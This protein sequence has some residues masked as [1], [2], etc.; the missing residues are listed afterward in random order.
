[1]KGKGKSV[2]YVRIF[3]DFIPMKFEDSLLKSSVKWR[4]EIF[5]RFKEL[6]SFGSGG[7]NCIEI[8]HTDWRLAL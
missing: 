1:M 6:S 2:R 5:V 3:N 7:E 4:P 8:F